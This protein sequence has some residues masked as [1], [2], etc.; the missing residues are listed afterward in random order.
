MI[1]IVK[2]ITYDYKTFVVY[3]VAIAIVN[4]VVF[5]DFQSN[6]HFRFFVKQQQFFFFSHEQ[7]LYA[8]LILFE[9]NIDFVLRTIRKKNNHITRKTNF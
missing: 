2:L 6:Q 5:V 3:N 9:Q 4:V 1:V 8:V 7:F